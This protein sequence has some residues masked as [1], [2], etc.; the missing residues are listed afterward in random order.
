M[1]LTEGLLI[2]IVIV[3]TVLVLT[4]RGKHRTTSSRSWDCVDRES[5]EVT[6]V[7]LAYTHSGQAGCKCPKCSSPEKNAAAEQ[8]EYFSVVPANPDVKG[9]LDCLCDGDDKFEYAVNEFGGPGLEYKDWVTAQA[10]DPQVMKNHSEFVKD[11]LDK[12]QWTGRT[13][14]PEVRQE[15]EGSDTVPWM[16]LRRPQHVAVHDPT[17]VTDGNE[18]SYT[19]TPTFTWKSS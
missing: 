19:N 1:T 16:G 6:S 18:N 3:L 2:V 12:G 7:K 15:L 11:R 4:G 8:H 10:V 5:G 13:Y 9:A 14:T 17:Q